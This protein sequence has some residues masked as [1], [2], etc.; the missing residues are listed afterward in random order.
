MSF[1]VY[2]RDG[3]ASPTSIEPP[4]SQAVGYVIV[5]GIG[6]V[7]AFGMV[8]VTRLLKETVGEDNEKTEMFMTANRSVRTGLTASAVV[9]GCEHL[10]VQPWELC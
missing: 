4:L 9:S 8:F 7:I 2:P 3:P 6:L 1:A 5:V 10:L